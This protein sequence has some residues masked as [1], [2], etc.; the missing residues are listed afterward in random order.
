MANETIW[1]DG[2]PTTVVSVASNMTNGQVAGNNAILDNSANRHTRAIATLFVGSF[3]TAPTADLGFE[4][5]MTRQDVDGND[6]DTAGSSVTSSPTAPSNGFLSTQGAQ[7]VGFFPV[8]QTTA[9]QRITREI[10]FDRVSK[11]KYFIRN[12]TGVTANAGSGTELTVKI[13]TFTPG[14]A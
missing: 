11:A 3:A 5:W 7:L 4:L 12:Q 6:D 13:V 8:A 10:A 2:S 9:A 1:T 14:T